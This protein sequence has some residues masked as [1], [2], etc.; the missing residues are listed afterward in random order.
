MR[1]KPRVSL[2]LKS[3]SHAYS[4]RDQLGRSS[5]VG[6]SHQQGAPIHQGKDDFEKLSLK[7]LAQNPQDGLPDCIANDD[8]ER[9]I[10]NALS[11][12]GDEEVC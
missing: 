12:S 10:A 8:G 6:R 1:L 3:V 9:Q 7:M 5:V 11:F 2:C 4:R